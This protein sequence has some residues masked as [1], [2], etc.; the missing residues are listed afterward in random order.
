MAR[1]VQKLTARTVAALNATGRCGEGRAVAPGLPFRHQGLALPLHAEWAR[2][3]HRP[4]VRS[5][6]S[7]AREKARDARRL[8]LAGIDWTP[9][10]RNSARRA[11]PQSAASR[12]SM[13]PK[14][15][16]SRPRLGCREAL[17]QRADSTTQH[18]LVVRLWHESAC[19][20]VGRAVPLCQV[21]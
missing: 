15:T 11:S 14:K 13:P 3:A 12:S 7:E 4:G 9:S 6:L 17:R 16:A 21:V 1:G 8:L 5:I 10:A 20:G 18:R 19:C 2:P